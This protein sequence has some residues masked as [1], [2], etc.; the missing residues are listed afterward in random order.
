MLIDKRLR[1]TNIILSDWENGCNRTK[2]NY[3]AA[4]LA[5]NIT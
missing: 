4:L 2:T 5:T 1:S 3:S